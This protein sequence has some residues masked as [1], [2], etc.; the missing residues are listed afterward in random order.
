[1]V[2]REKGKRTRLPVR[3][4]NYADSETMII[5]CTIFKN[6]AAA[7]DDY[8]EEEKSWNQRNWINFIKGDTNGDYIF[9][10]QTALVLAA[11]GIWFVEIIR[12]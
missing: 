4:F 9:C 2:P 5:S 8:E 10:R 11:G 1:M 12:G 7:D 3:E 6:N